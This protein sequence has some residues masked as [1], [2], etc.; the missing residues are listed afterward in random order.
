LAK[1]QVD[2][3]DYKAADNNGEM[4][5][6]AKLSWAG[7][8][9]AFIGLAATL[10]TANPA[11]LAVAAAGLTIALVCEALDRLNSYKPA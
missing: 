2:F 6:L 5:K 7:L 1:M 8:G 10:V 11:F 9:T 4:S 3:K